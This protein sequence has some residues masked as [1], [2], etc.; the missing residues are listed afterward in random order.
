MVGMTDVRFDANEM[1]QNI[2]RDTVC[3]RCQAC[4]QRV[5]VAHGHPILTGFGHGGVNLSYR[6]FAFWGFLEDKTVTQVA[7]ELDLNDGIVAEL[8][9]VARTVVADDMLHKQSSLQFAGE[10]RSTV[11]I[12]VDESC[13][14]HWSIQR[15]VASE[16][17]H[18]FY[19][20]IGLC[21]RGDLSKLFLA[22]IVQRAELPVGVAQSAGDGRPPQ[23]RVDFWMEIARKVFRPDSNVVLHSDSAPAYRSTC[24]PG[25]VERHQVNHSAKE[26]C[27]SIEILDNVDADARPLCGHLLVPRLGEGRG[28]EATQ[29]LSHTTLEPHHP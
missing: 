26:F 15:D 12:E 27:R 19:V 23:L 2:T 6:I 1:V 18:Y 25:V 7:R 16:R 20:W 8:F 22:P 5:H 4:R 14:Q 29:P 24:P 21:Q 11:E 28:N 17:E 3:Y 13:F 9:D 10:G